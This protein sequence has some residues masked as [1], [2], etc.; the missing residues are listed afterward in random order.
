[1]KKRI[2]SKKKGNTA[3]RAIVKILNDFYKTEEFKRV[4]TSGMFGNIHST[5]LSENEAKIFTGD[6]IVPD[7]FKYAL[8]VKHYADID[9]WK[10]MATGETQWDEQLAEEEKNLKISKKKGIILV[11][12]KNRRDWMV[13]FKKDLFKKSLIVNSF[14]KIEFEEKIIIPFQMF[15]KNFMKEK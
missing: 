3:E 10:I 14:P 15:L 13:M 9:L 5:N 12:K 8:E 11:F 7:W 6:V 2:N 4:P 1:M